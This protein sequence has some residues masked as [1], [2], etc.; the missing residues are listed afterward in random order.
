M[1]QVAD[2]LPHGAYHEPH[3]SV[4]VMPRDALGETRALLVL[5]FL[6]GEPW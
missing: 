1:Q 3:R 2:A 5:T 6:V 4:G